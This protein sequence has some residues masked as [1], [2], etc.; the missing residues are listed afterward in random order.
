[1]VK[2]LLD[3]FSLSL[4]RLL[5]AQL[6]TTRKTWRSLQE[7][8]FT[9]LDD[10]L[11]LVGGAIGRGAGAMKLVLQ[12]RCGSDAVQTTWSEWEETSGT[13]NELGSAGRLAREGR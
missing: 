7:A 9:K 4:V 1:M 2:L 3:G 5:G 11:E 13:A 8:T 6:D 10:S 12:G